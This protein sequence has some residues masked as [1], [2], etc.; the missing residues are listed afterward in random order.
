[1]L[2]EI[3]RTCFT[4]ELSRPYYVSRKSNSLLL[5]SLFSTLTAKCMETQT[6]PEVT[7]MES[8]WPVHQ[9]GGF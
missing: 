8:F 4:Q 6:T 3:N 7:R 1:M 9:P 2:T 5:T